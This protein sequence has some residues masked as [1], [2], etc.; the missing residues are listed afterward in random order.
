MKKILIYCF[1]SLLTLGANAQE[2]LTLQN[3][4][5]MALENN[6][7]MAAAAMQTK[8]SKYMQKR[9]RKFGAN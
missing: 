4:R 9:T 7:Q 6:K 1:M 5:D 2:V 3:C 8:S